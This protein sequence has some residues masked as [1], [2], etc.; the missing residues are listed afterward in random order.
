MSMRVT[1]AEASRVLCEHAKAIANQMSAEGCVI[2]VASLDEAVMGSATAA[3][4]SAA[5]AAAVASV[6]A[7]AA[8]LCG[9]GVV[10]AAQ[11]DGEPNPRMTEALSAG[12]DKALARVAQTVAASAPA[13]AK[14]DACAILILADDDEAAAVSFSPDASPDAARRGLAYRDAIAEVMGVGLEIVGGG[15]P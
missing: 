15:G 12:E 10:L 8:R 3:S 14:S 1:K 6:L 2:F 11:S 9:D 13:L 5:A 4:A 7:V